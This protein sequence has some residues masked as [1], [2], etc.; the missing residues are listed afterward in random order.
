MPVPGIY[1]EWSTGP[2]FHSKVAGANLPLGLGDDR[3]GNEIELQCEGLWEDSFLILV[4]VAVVAQKIN[5][6]EVAGSIPGPTQ[7]VRDPALP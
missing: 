3:K 6:H 7:W 5:I 4:G 2:L 1:E